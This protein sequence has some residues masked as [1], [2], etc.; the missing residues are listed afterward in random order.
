MAI[1]IWWYKMKFCDSAIQQLLNGR[2]RVIYPDGQRSMKMYYR[3]AKSY[4]SIFGGKVI[5]E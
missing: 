5:F 4:A 1:K 3:N 2:F